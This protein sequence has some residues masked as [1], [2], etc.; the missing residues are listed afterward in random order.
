MNFIKK[1]I[2]KLKLQTK[3][4]QEQSSL[5]IRSEPLEVQTAMIPRPIVVFQGFFFFNQ[6]LI[7]DF[8]AD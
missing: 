8:R 7:I 5:P 1:R 6:S 4:K 3:M 2:L